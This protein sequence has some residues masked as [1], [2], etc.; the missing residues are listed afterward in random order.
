MNGTD[1]RAIAPGDD[2]TAIS[3]IYEQSWKHAYRGIVPQ[4]Y[5]DAIP[6]GRWADKLDTPGW[7]TL[8]C[9][10]GGRPV[11]TCS[12]CASRFPEYP[13]CGEIISIYF[14]PEY[15]GRGFGRQLLGAAVSELRALGFGEIFLWV[16][17]ENARA[18]RFYERFGFAPTEDLL[19]DSIG[20]KAL[21]EMR[22]VL[23]ARDGHR[24]INTTT[25]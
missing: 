3:G 25:D 2:R 8:V 10:E 4:A 11:G 23:N 12:F 22:Y 19:D 7:H 9:L 15:T 1:I 17:E 16:L 18:R 21:R 13:G 24:T 20:G 6:P 5:L 14:L